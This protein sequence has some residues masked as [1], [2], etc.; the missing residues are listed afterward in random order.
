MDPSERKRV[1]VCF[2]PG[3]FNLYSNDFEIVVVI[4]VLRATSAIC[5]AMEHGVKSIIPVSS[6]EEARAYQLKGYITAAERGGQIV[7][8][9]EL[10]NSPF[11]YMNPELKG[12]TVVMTTTNGTK[13]IN[14]AKAMPTVVIGSLN[15]LEAVC[16]FLISQRKSVIVL[17]SGWMDKFNLEDTICA[18]AIA[19]ELIE[20]GG[21]YAEEDSSIA[22]KFIYRSARENIFSFLK[23]SSHRRRLRK[24]KLNKDVRYCLT[25]NII[26]SI[27]VLKDGHIVR[28]AYEYSSENVQA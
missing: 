5:T 10:G 6:I 20:S 26:R 19:D 27:P 15:N 17:G 12:K 23:A 21:F 1:E 9:F 28:L 18:G 7:E 13:S 11:S 25:P 2:T 24:L 4:D 14:L 8:G 22:A 3:Q 16:N